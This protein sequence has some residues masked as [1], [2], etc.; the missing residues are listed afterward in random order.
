MRVQIF[1]HPWRTWQKYHEQQ[2][3]IT[4]PWQPEV[5][6]PCQCLQRGT[7]SSIASAR[8]G[9]MTQENPGRQMGTTLFPS[10]PHKWEWVQIGAYNRELSPGAPWLPSCCPISPVLASSAAQQSSGL[11]EAVQVFFRLTP[12][13]NCP[14]EDCVRVALPCMAAFRSL[15][16]SWQLMLIG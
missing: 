13:P 11:A 2:G 15:T 8:G 1:L 3:R 12:A 10:Q 5:R 9:F 16:E 7:Y 4:F 6:K 14:C